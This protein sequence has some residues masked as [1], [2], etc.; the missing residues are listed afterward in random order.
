MSL[1]R[2]V[3][4]WKRLSGLHGD[5]QI[6]IDRL[7]QSIRLQAAGRAVPVPREGT[8]PLRDGPMGAL[9]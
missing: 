7:V 6:R 5:A 1:D 4:A 9:G 3:F 8:P 2:W